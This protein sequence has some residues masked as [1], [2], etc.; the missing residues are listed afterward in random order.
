[1]PSQILS[2]G[3]DIGTSTTQVIFSRLLMD[4]MADYFS[5]PRISIV[6]KELV[7]KSPVHLTPLKTPVL[8][9]GEGVRRIVEDEY[10][11]AEFTP[12]DVD[13]GAVI[14]TGES[15]RKE[16]AAEVTAQL[17]GFAG[18]FV[19]ST[20]GPDLESVIAGKGSGAY[21]YSLDNHC[22]V[23]N[24]DIGGGTTN[25]VMFDE[26]QT[27][28]KGCMDIGG[29][30]IRLDRDGTV[31]YISPSVRQIADFLNI[32]LSIG[33][34]TTRQS[35]RPIT[36]KMADLLAQSIGLGERERLF[37]RVVTANSTPLA[38]SI[39][40]AHYIC[41]SGGVADCIRQPDG[42]WLRYGDIGVLL[43]ESIAAHPLFASFRL[44]PA[45][46]TI[47]ATVVGAGTYTTS[48]SG[49]TIAYSNKLFPLK[50]IPVL[51]LDTDEQQR[52]FDGDSQWL[53]EKAR[54]FMS[55]SDSDQFILAMGGKSD[56]DYREI[57][58]LARCIFDA[59]DRV[60]PQGKPVLVV[61]EN[62][63]AKALGF[64]LRGCAEDKRKVAAIDSI[65]VE[66]ND[67]IDI[68][69][70]LMDGLVVPVIVKTLVFG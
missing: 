67:Y 53:T 41:F 2:V 36:D 26:G 19:V 9:D 13:T 31:T 4:N 48:I 20:A 55:Q 44:L 10:R 27:V 60:L 39:K 12:A 21:Q 70:P 5:A 25:I 37:D 18:E 49:S 65:A 46:E 61:L 64:A 57:K 28:L 14:I 68:G 51:K 38:Q 7:Y 52:C 17:S 35:L 43:G 24:L 16:N 54:W 58:R 32:P 47:R 63:M 34:K 33:Q 8:I 62:D 29:R 69:R 3:I 22:R 40:P 66:V 42:D 6:G 23:V 15:A 45:G 50:N 1:M 59:S 56:P 30:L 11:K